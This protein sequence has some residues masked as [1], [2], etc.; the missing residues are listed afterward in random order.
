M[1]HMRKPEACDPAVVPS[2][3]L[4]LPLTAAAEG[5]RAEVTCAGS[6]NGA[7]TVHHASHIFLVES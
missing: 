4:S 7:Q 2:W 6:Q 5:N 3:Q 1:I